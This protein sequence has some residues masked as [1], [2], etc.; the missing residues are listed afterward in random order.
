MA[1]I[2]VDPRMFDPARRPD[3]LNEANVLVGSPLTEEQIEDLSAILDVYFP[4]RPED[5]SD[6]LDMTSA[7]FAM[8]AVTSMSTQSGVAILAAQAASA[9]DLQAL[10]N[11]V[12]A[13]EN[14]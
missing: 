1:L 5:V 3:A 2:D 4:T 11:R 13:L 10:A 12:T 8:I 6:Y 9:N 7:Y 14:A